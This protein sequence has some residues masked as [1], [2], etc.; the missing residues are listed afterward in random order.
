MNFYTGGDPTLDPVF[1]ILKN[2]TKVPEADE[3]WTVKTGKDDHDNTRQIIR[4]FG[5][6]KPVVKMRELYFNGRDLEKRF[7][8]PWRSDVFL[9]GTD[10]LSFKPGLTIKDKPWVFIDD[11]FR[12]GS[13]TYRNTKKYQNF[14]LLRFTIDKTLI[15]NKTNYPYNGVFYSDKYNGFGNLTSVQKAPVFVSKPYYKDCIHFLN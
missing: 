14:N 7:T 10:A 5:Y 8:N 13:F 12:G 2:M 11:I 6:E 15:L 3:I 9:N 4:A 1:T